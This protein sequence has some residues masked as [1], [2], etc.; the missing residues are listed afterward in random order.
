MFNSLHYG[1]EGQPAFATDRE[2]Q[3][4][5]EVLADGIPL[6]VGGVDLDGEHAFHAQ[7]IDDEEIAVRITVAAIAF[8][9]LFQAAIDVKS[10]LHLFLFSL[11]DSHG[12]F[13]RVV[14][15]G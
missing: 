8:F 9:L 15:L 11:I 14:G 4:G 12:V 1:R 13:L 10:L 2:V 7:G 6:E 5:L 3:G